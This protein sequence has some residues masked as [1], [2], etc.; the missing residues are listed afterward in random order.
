MCWTLKP[1]EVFENEHEEMGRN[2]DESLFIYAFYRPGDTC[3]FMMH[4]GRAQAGVVDISRIQRMEGGGN[5]LEGFGTSS[6]TENA[7]RTDGVLISTNAR[8]FDP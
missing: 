7:P 4:S 1:V 3:F 2:G 6:R 8:S 5:A